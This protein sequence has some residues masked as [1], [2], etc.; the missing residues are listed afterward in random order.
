M[1]PFI[2]CIFSN[3]S[4]LSCWFIVL[5]TR[6]EQSLIIV[7]AISNL[8]M[9][10]TIYTWLYIMN[11]WLP[12]IIILCYPSVNWLLSIRYIEIEVAKVQ[13]DGGQPRT[14]DFVSYPSVNADC[15]VQWLLFKKMQ[16]LQINPLALTSQTMIGNV[17]GTLRRVATTDYSL[18]LLNSIIYSV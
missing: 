10:F 8:L 6:I 12:V 9:T 5:K 15:I 16:D 7:N 2:P 13:D 4:G 11:Q 18:L 17:P 14:N 1:T 3:N